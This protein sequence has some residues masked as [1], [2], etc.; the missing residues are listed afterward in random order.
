M[1]A[2]RYIIPRVLFW[3]TLG[4]LLTEL[5]QASCAKADH[6]QHVARFGDRAWIADELKEN[7]Q[8]KARDAG[9]DYQHVPVVYREH[10][11]RTELA[12]T[13]CLVVNHLASER[14]GLARRKTVMAHCESQKRDWLGGLYRA[15]E[16][17]GSFPYVLAGQT[18]L[19]VIPMKTVH[20]VLRSTILHA[21]DTNRH[22]I[23]RKLIVPLLEE[24]CAIGSCGL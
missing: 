18:I 10:E 6:T 11:I 15:M 24:A 19:A 23:F 20:R 8:I 4:Y 5:F 21:N 13:G 22:D 7:F 14:R 16:D 2:A 12:M 3:C 1:T 9:Y 17:S